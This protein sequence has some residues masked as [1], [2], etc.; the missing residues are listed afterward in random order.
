MKIG[1]DV[2]GVLTNVE[3]YVFENF[4]KYCYE[5]NIDILNIKSEEYDTADIYNT[6]EEK[7][8]EIWDEL[9]LEYVK[10]YPARK[11]ASEII[12]KLKEMGHEI[13]IITAR[14]SSTEEEISKSKVENSTINWLDQ[15]NIKYDEVIF[16]K[17]KEKIIKEKQIDIMIEDSPKNIKK[18]SEICQVFIFGCAYNRNLQKYGIIVNSWYEV[19]AHIENIEKNRKE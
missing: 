6:T 13:Y 19:L 4:G 7:D 15:N 14:T 17:A 12:A 2:D 9:F 5:H 8:L 16:E 1:I 11:F 10:T 3:Q 18:L